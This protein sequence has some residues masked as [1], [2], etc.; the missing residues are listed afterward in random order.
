MSGE[1]NET[2]SSGHTRGFVVFAVRGFSWA[3]KLVVVLGALG[4]ISV[5]LAQSGAH[6]WLRLSRDTNMLSQGNSGSKR[7][8]DKWGRS[9]VMQS[10]DAAYLCATTCGINSEYVDIFPGGMIAVC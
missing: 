8:G 1:G 4:K 7:K 3:V 10:N 5:A 2:E 6:A 9:E